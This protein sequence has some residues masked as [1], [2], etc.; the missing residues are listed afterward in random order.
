[1]RTIQITY[2]IEKGTKKKKTV[3]TTN[4]TVAATEK[5]SSLNSIDASVDSETD[6]ETESL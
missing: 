1:M 2:D 3:A 6:A 4:L 5:V